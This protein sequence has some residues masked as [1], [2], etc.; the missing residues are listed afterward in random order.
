M[1][2]L[3]RFFTLALVSVACASKLNVRQTTNTNAAIISIL[4]SLDETMHQVGPTVL[5]EMANQTLSDTTVGQQ[6]AMLNTAFNKTA[7][8]LAGTAV[9]AGSTTVKPTNDDVSVTYADSLQLVASTLSGIKA[10]GKV[11]SFSTM[12]STLDPIMAKATTQ[13]NVTLPGSLILVTDLMKD[14]QQFLT[15]EGF[16][17]T[18]TALGFA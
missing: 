1:F 18:R 6:M 3:R 10:T 16:T 5:T 11:P 12:V 14:A 7:T 4:D 13:L 17:L 9:S 8:G 2:T 15:A